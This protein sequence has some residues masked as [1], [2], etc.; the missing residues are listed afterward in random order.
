MTETD[1]IYN[2]DCI[3]GMKKIPSNSID[4]VLTDP[5]YNKLS[6]KWDKPID[7]EKFWVEIKRIIK[8]NGAIIMTASQPFT[9]DLINSNRE[10]F[11]YELIWE[12]SKISGHMQAKRKPLTT[13]ENILVFGEFSLS[14]QYG[15]HGIYNLFSLKKISEKINYNGYKENSNMGKRKPKSYEKTQTNYPKSILKFN[16]EEGLH[17]TQKP[18]SLFKWLIK[19][20]SNENQLVLD[21]FGGSGTTAIACMETKRRYILFENNPQYFKISLDRINALVSNSKGSQEANSPN[22]SYQ[23]PTSSPPKSAEPTSDNNNIKLNST[24]Q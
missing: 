16:S 13:H 8:P 19:S 24:N 12:K 10:M 20:Y 22:I 2:E 5:P 3:E 7:L 15:V 9:T 21:C 11:K 1:K 17:P 4:L 23:V 6:C 18:T 14:A